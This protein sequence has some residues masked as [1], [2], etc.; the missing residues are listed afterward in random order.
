MPGTPRAGS[1][2]TTSPRT[3]TP[4]AS[5]GAPLIGWWPGYDGRMQKPPAG[6][7]MYAVQW[8]WHP[9]L[10]VDGVGVPTTDA[11]FGPDLEADRIQAFLRE[12][13]ARGGDAAK[14]F[15]VFWTPN[16]P[17]MDHELNRG[18]QPWA[19]TT[20]PPIPG[21][22]Q[23]LDAQGRVPGSLANSVEYLDHL[24][25]RVLDTVDELGLTRDTIVVYAGD[26]GTTGYGKGRFENEV[27]P[28]V[29]FV[30]SAPGFPEAARGAQDAMIDFTDVL[31]TLADLAGV[32]L[33]P[34]RDVDGHSFAPL[35]TGG[36]F[37]PR[38]YV[39]CEFGNGRWLRD[40]RY[41]LDAFGRF[42]DTH[43]GR[44]ETAGYTDVTASENPEVIA[45]RRRFEAYLA[46]H[47]VFAYPGGP[48]DD[49]W[50]AF[51]KG[52][53]QDVPVKRFVPDYVEVAPR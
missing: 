32:T 10:V 38:R 50:D 6:A 49:R 28:R 29:P 22:G 27:G 18:A 7:G 41:L 3:P 15:F 40:E 9:G 2:R 46:E 13:A 37:E 4:W 48:M 21:R 30:V 25:G 5:I 52:G 53:T 47:S 16:L 39:L 44:D 45:A 14:P 34:D 31:P 36:A 23:S 1:A 20:T 33:G 24:L 42:F 19:Y 51:F 11:D 12:T 17:H 43:G 26:N 35:I 8:Y